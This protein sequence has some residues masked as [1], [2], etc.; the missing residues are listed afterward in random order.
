VQVLGAGG[1]GGKANAGTDHVGI[2]DLV[3]PGR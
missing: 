1:R 3:L 2:E